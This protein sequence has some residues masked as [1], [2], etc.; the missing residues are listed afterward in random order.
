MSNIVN[1]NQSD[2][3]RLISL[4]KQGDE[5][6]FCVLI[7]RY[8]RRLFSVA[9][10]I[11]LDKEDS[12]EIVQE[13]FLK[14]YQNIRT[15]R[16]EAR[17]STWLHRITINQCLNWRR[18]WKRKL[19]WHHQSLETGAV[20]VCAELQSDK[21]SADTLYE[22]KELRKIFRKWLRTLPEEARAVFV[23]REVEGLSYEEIAKILKIKQGTVS[24]RLFYTRKRL[25]ELLKKYENEK[26]LHNV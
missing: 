7:R 4:L 25:K 23:F 14:V 5:A 12:L 22:K 16:E 13:V 6:A 1:G 9:Y 21:D 3:A 18:K 10:G 20:A 17:L 24:S 19:R 15:F 2:E 8:Q 26:G 11:T